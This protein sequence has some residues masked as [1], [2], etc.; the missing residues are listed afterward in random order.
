MTHPDREIERSLAVL[1]GLEISGVSHA[2]DML[3]LSFGPLR[4]V[5]T[6]RGTTKQVGAWA[7]HVQCRWTIERA[8]HVLATHSDFGG[9]DDQINQMTEEIRALVVA[10]VPATVADV[11]AG[12]SG[13]VSL[14]LSK[15]LQIVITPDSIADG[16]D[17]RFFTPSGDGEHL[18]IVGDTVIRESLS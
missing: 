3:T 11:Q 7:L 6:R 13:G 18:V 2:A 1:V 15:G 17:W 12:E 14:V 10:S 16:E 9:S 5:T 8:D 4:T